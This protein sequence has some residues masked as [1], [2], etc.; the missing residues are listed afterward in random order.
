MFDCTQPAMILSF[1]TLVFGIIIGL[2]AGI[3][4]EDSFDLLRYRNKDRGRDSNDG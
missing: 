3:A 2:F 4:I 1:L